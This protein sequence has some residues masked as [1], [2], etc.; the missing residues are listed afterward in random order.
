MA[1]LIQIKRAI[2]ATAPGS[3][4]NGELAYSG[5][6]T[7]DS[8]FIGNP[9][10]GAVTRIGG[11]K[12]GHVFSATPGTLTANAT[13]ITNSDGFI[14]TIKV[15]NTTVNS[16]VNS[17][18]VALSN[19]SAAIVITIPTAAAISNGQYYLNANGA[20]SLVDTSAATAGSNTQIFFNDSGFINASSGFVFNKASNNLTVANTITVGSATINSTI[21]TG[22]SY[23]ANDASY[24]NGNTASDLQT[25]ADDKA[26]NAY[27]NATSYADTAAGTAYSNATSYADTAAGTAY[28][29]ATSYADT[30]AGTAYSNATSYA[31]TAAA[32]AYSNA[33]S[34]ADTAAATAYSNATS[35]ADTAAATAYSNATSYADTAAATAYSNAVSY[36]DDKSANAYS[37]AMSDTLSRNGS[38]TGNNTFGGS[39]TIFSSNVV[40]Q[41]DIGSNIVPTANV[42]YNVGDSLLRWQNLFVANVH[43]IDGY[44]DGSVSIAGNLTVSGNVVTTN[45][46]SVIV[47]D[48][49]IYLAGNNYSSDLVDIGFAGNYYDGSDNRHAGLF[50]DASDGEFKIFT[51]LTQELD[52]QLTVN[53][54]DPTFAIATLH[55]YLKSGGLT[56]NTTVVNITANSTVSVAL[57]ANTLS[58]TS[59]LPG[60]SGG[61]GLNS[62]TSQDIL[63]ANS[64][65]GLDKL[66]LGTAGY[67][68]QSNGTALIYSTLDGGTF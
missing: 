63:V 53:T 18:S 32:T 55:T 52:D 59:P 62:Y 27:S 17:T 60:T 31:D 50:R 16:V 3:L 2:T 7:S 23:T 58:L 4:A 33:T 57:T 34:Y 25:Y 24:L 13:V 36:A 20:Y 28:S 49:L 35:Y 42:T 19:S 61:T 38:Y 56:S 46:Q 48:P 43:S 39:N 45:V 64:T 66:S 9:N 26:A 65:N 47:S 14:D 10:G 68:L 54:A 67:V 22:E 8:L 37:N 5:N 44:Y 15:G 41:G 51:N 40:F 29:N 30:A 1:N 21:Y 12:F 6:T 11:E